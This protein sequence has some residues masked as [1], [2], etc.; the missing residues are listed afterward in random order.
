MVKKLAILVLAG[1]VVAP[2]GLFASTSFDRY[3]VILNRKPFGSPPP[4]PEVVK[5]PPPR[6][7]SFAKSLRLSMIVETDDG[8]VRIGFV[9]NRSGRSYSLIPGEAQDGIEL[10][11][12]SFDDE[13]AIIKSGDEMAL[14]KIASG[15]FQEIAPADQQSRI[16][17]ARN[18]PSYQERRRQRLEQ[19]A[20]QAQA[21][22]PEAK[23]TG[24]AL[25]RHL[26]DYQMEVIRQGLPPLP[27][28]L[29]PEQDAQ[30]VAEGYLP[31]LD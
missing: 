24:E 2:S 26:H 18:R 16:E 20:Q 9:D 22:P 3:Q 30:L 31:P 14:L 6:A 19:Q 5:P 10:V 25:T 27:I 1:A 4:P 21:P 7:D 8:D 28:P 13:E 15:T 17:Q 12:A 29:T 23:Y 11:S